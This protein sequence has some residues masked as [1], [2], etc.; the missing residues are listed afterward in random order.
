MVRC[1]GRKSVWYWYYTTKRSIFVV[2]NNLVNSK[3]GITIDL[4]LG[5]SIGNFLIGHI[6][7]FLDD[8]TLFS[9]LKLNQVIE[10]I[11]QSDVSF[12]NSIDLPLPLAV[13][14]KDILNI[15]I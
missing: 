11:A 6:G 7:Y 14:Y 1:Y 15:T 8:E 9:I 10:K 5:L 13:I 3:M 4:T 12:W 2:Y